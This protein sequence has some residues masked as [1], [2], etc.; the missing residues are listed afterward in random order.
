MPIMLARH[1]N[2]L[3]LSLHLLTLHMGTLVFFLTKP[4]QNHSMPHSTNHNLFQQLFATGATMI[5]ITSHHYFA[6]HYNDAQLKFYRTSKWA[7]DESPSRYTTRQII[8][9]NTGGTRVHST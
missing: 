2:Q 4:I 8:L 6:G 3:T 1:I 5:S 7:D 9:T